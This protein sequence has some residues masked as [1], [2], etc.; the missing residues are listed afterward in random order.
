MGRKYT[1]PAHRGGVAFC[2]VETGDGKQIA[3]TMGDAG[4]QLI[5]RGRAYEPSPGDHTIWRRSRCTT[6]LTQRLSEPSAGPSLG[7]WGSTASILRADS[8]GKTLLVAHGVEP[9]ADR[10][11]SYV[12]ACAVFSGRRLAHFAVPGDIHYRNC[13]FSPCGAGRSWAE[14]STMSVLGRPCSPQPGKPTRGN[15]CRFGSPTIA[16]CWPA[17]LVKKDP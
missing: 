4:S 5:R 17:G 3:S 8:R 16:A 7:K 14:R 1:P 11:E 10:K 6:R 13:P 15:S 12:T 2:A 9:N